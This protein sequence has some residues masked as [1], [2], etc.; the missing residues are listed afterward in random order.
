MYMILLPVLSLLSLPLLSCNGKDKESDTPS[1]DSS[2]TDTDTGTVIDTGDPE[3]IPLNGLCA[4]PDRW[5]RFIV[6]S[7]IDYAYISGSVSDGVVPVNILTEVQTVGGC[8]IWRRENPFCDPSCESDET[9]DFDGTCIPYPAA[10]SLGTVTIG[11]LL[12]PA[13]MEP[14]PPSMQYFLTRLPNPPWTTGG[15]IALQ[16]SGGEFDPVALHGI[17][18]DALQNVP[19][20]WILRAGTPLALTWDLPAADTPCADRDEPIQ[21]LDPLDTGADNEMMLIRA[22]AVFDPIFPMT[23]LG[24]KLKKDE[25]G[26]GYAIIARSA[27]VNEPE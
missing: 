10:S 13:S 3:D 7:N 18:V 26:G 24:L 17:G 1:T 21:L 19:P 4:E 25:F 22:C 12:E 27:F 8:T 23:G 16:S 9:C 6:D 11:G 5:G 20:A 14:V 2:A 15:L